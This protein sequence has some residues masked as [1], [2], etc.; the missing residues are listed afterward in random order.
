M[1]L[2]EDIHAPCTLSLRLPDGWQ[3][4]SGLDSISSAPQLLD[5]PILVG[6]LHRWTFT[7]DGIPHEVAYLQAT[8][9]LGF[10]SAALVSNIQKI[11]RATR[12]IFGGFPYKHYSFLLEPGSGGALEHGNSVTIGVSAADLSGEQPGIYEE[13]AHEFFHTW[14]LMHIR[15]AG[16]TELNYGPQQ[17]SPGLWFSEGVTMLYA[18]LICRRTGLPVED[19]NRIA[20][21]SSLI[22]RYYSDTG[23]AVLA[24]SRVSLASNLQPGPLGD[25]TA[26]T[27]LQ[28][29]LLGECLDMLIRDA[30]DG[31]RSFDDVMKL[32]YKRFGQHQPLH[33]SDVESVVTSVCQC[34]AAHAFFQTYLYNGHPID[35]NSSLHLLGLRMQR[36]QTAATDKLGQPLPDKRVYAWVL[37]DD[38]SLRILITNP[39]SCWALGDL[40]TGDI[41]ISL[42][43]VPM[44][45]RQDFQS[46]LATIQ[47]GDTLNIETKKGIAMVPH[48]VIIGGY[49][50]PLI[51]ISAEPTVTP[52]QRRMLHNWWFASR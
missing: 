4:A 42:N 45:T 30:T 43:G 17:Q 5:A 18:D 28:G 2:V 7:V 31:R 37:R 29:E 50:I 47:I 12:D 48:S 22:T 23:N 21:L 44:H 11:V 19:S 34:S 27:H 10:D 13:I 52:R 26:S 8:P 51:N 3:A 46:A 15:P 20:Y 33:D 6:R 36:G 25:Y 41:I 1:Y 35:F 9:A 40:H 16:Y 39:N 49:T 14:N 32:I 38:T 24:P